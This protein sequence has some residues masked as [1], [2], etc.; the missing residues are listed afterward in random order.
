MF[1]KW[2]PF[3]KK[4][5]YRFLV[6]SAKIENVTFSYKTP[7][8]EAIVM[9]NRMGSTKWTYRKDWSFAIDFFIFNFF[10]SLRTSSKEF[11]LMY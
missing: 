6:E 10:F 2:K 8:S 4:L 3:L 9:T 1:Q 5:E 11:I 7:L